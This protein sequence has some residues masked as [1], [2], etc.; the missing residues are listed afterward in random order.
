MRSEPKGK[1]GIEFSKGICGRTKN[2]QIGIVRMA[3]WLDLW[4]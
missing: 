3:S 4:T 1:S 2:G